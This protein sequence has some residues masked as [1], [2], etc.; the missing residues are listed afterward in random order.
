VE[1]TEKAPYVYLITVLTVNILFLQ[2]LDVYSTRV[3]VRLEGVSEANE[4]LKHYQHHLPTFERFMVLLKTAWVTLLVSM[5][6]IALLTPT[7][8][9][10][11]IWFFTFLSM[12]VLTYWVVFNNLN[13]ALDV[14]SSC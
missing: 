9:V 3:A 14:I 13:I 12:L 4:Y 7:P 8:S 2:I 10:R 11:L 5:Y 1:V 6:I